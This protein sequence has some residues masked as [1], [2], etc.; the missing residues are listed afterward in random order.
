MS[1]ELRAVLYCFGFLSSILFGARFIVQW[2]HSERVGRSAVPRLFWQLSLIGNLSLLVHSVIQVQYP[3]ALAQTAN[4]VIS[5]RNLNLM[6]KSVRPTRHVLIYLLAGL[7]GCTAVFLLQSWLLIGHLDWVRTPTAPWQNHSSDSLPLA[8]HIWGSM[9]IVLFASRFWVQWWDSERR[10]E[11]HMSASFWWMSLVG[12]MIALSYFL[13]LGDSV[14]IIGYATGLVPYARNLMLLRRKPAA[15]QVSDV[16]LFAGENSGDLH[17]GALLTALRRQQP[18]LQVLGVGGPQMRAAGMDIVLPMEEFQVM[19]FTNAIKALPRMIRHFRTVRNAI[20]QA[21]PKVVV[22]ID[23]P[24]LNLRL[25]KSLRKRGYKGKLIHYVCPTIW[26]HGKGRKRTLVKTLDRLLCI[27][28]FEPA[29][30]EDSE[31]RAEYIGNPLVSAA[32]QHE[33]NPTWRKDYEIPSDKRLVALM[34]GSRHGEIKHHLPIMLRSAERLK[35]EFPD[36]HFVLPVANPKLLPGID[37]ALANS[38]IV[39]SIIP[40]S[41]RFDLMH[42]SHLALAASG[43]VTLELGLFEVP[44]VVVY[45][46]STLNYFI[47]QYIVRLR[48]THYCLTNILA[49]YKTVFPE[50]LY[51]LFNEDNVTREMRRLLVDEQWRRACISGCQEVKALLGA[52]DATQAAADQVSDFL[53]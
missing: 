40:A 30:F 14:N 19:G 25:A 53:S 38:T 21:A 15:R 51:K 13:R 31:L 4:A 50:L 48:L 41:Q 36:L 43:T 5:W 46:V 16:F 1:D 44:T 24:G 27:F 22:L 34:P 42:D 12:A 32:A 18:E 6:G 9:G 3:V 47:A 10:Q 17:G 26:A 8:W 29:L 45:H 2:L 23:Y 35:Q 20:L 28:P 39:P 52:H 37:S 49:G 11:S 33:Y 7:L